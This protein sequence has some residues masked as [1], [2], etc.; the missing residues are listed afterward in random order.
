MELTP[1]SIRALDITTRGLSELTRSRHG[2]SYSNGLEKGTGV[3]ERFETVV[4]SGWDVQLNVI[5]HWNFKDLLGLPNYQQALHRTKYPGRPGISDPRLLRARKSIFVGHRR[6]REL[7][8][9]TTVGANIRDY[10][11][12][13]S[14]DLMMKRQSNGSIEVHPRYRICPTLHRAFVVCLWSRSRIV[15]HAVL[16]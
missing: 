13:H 6:Y 1:V 4:R 10:Y 12:D 11:E 2:H 9:S 5:N 3:S 14:I 8:M 7:V 15:P 16:M